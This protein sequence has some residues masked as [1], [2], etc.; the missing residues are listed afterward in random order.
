[1]SARGKLDLGDVK[2]LAVNHV[3]L[4]ASMAVEVISTGALT[5]K[6]FLAGM[7][8]NLLRHVAQ[9]KPD[10]EKPGCA[11]TEEGDDKG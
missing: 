6:G 1:M 11:P 3:P 8:I 5:W 7:G 4:L 2:T 9:N 10:D